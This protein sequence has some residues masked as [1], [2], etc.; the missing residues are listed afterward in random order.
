MELVNE[1]LLNI[2]KQ[3]IP[4]K[5]FMPDKSLVF[6]YFI[7]DNYDDLDN[8]YDDSVLFYISGMN[9]SI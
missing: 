7:Y 8:D 1:Q 6:K 4:G 2:W 3:I 9:K 5:P